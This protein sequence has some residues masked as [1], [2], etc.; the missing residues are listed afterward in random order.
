MFG[1]YNTECTAG[2][3]CNTY[4]CRYAICIIVHSGLKGMY[5]YTLLFCSVAP[6]TS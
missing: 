4:V 3:I 6:T 1:Q 2:N 5:V